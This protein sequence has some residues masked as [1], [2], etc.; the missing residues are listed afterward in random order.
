M[1][2]L[3][4]C[5]A[6]FLSLVPTVSVFALPRAARGQQTATSVQH[7]AQAVAIV[8]QSVAAMA[9]SAPSDSTAVGTVTIVEGSTTQSGTIQVLTLGTDRTS[10]TLNLASGTRTVIYSNG[11]AKEIT[12]T[13]AADPPLET[14]VTDQCP[15][16]PLPLLLGALNK[17]DVSFVYVGAETLN[18]TA[19]QHVRFWNSFASKPRHQKLAPFSLRDIWLDASSGLP[20]KVAYLRRAGG[21]ATPAIPVEVFFANYTNSGGVL[22]PFEINKSYNGTPWQTITIQS[23]M[24]D[25]GLTKSQFI[26]ECGSTP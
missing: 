25:T 2:V 19:V 13:Q 16:F 21:G 22:Y 10:E 1:C 18:G 5:L 4:V 15:D 12:G 26:I 20:L 24:F 7:D 11:D 6:L 3:R 14:I 9:R 17:A 23:V 8:Q